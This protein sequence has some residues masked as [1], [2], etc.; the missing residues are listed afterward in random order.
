MSPSLYDVIILVILG[1][2][3]LIGFVRGALREVMTVLAFVGA[4]AASLFALRVTGP[5]ARHLIEPAWAGAVAAVLVVFVAAY[6]V[7]RVLG[8]GLQNRVHQTTALGAID[9]SIGVGF[10]L[11]RGL[12]AIGVFHLVFHAATPEDRVPQWISHA[13]LYPLSKTCAKALSKPAPEGSAVAGRLGPHLGDA[14][15][16]G[17]EDPDAGDAPA[18]LTTETWR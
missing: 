9:R 15:R 2:S 14:V 4:V 11:L 16:K 17:S 3:A 6:I 10:G 18:G 8:A 5:I 13:T 12:V 1:S 7:I